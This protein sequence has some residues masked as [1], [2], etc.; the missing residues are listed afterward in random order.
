MVVAVVYGY[1]EFDGFYRPGSLL[2]VLSCV[3]AVLRVRRTTRPAW[4]A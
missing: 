1:V 2:P 3:G 4:D